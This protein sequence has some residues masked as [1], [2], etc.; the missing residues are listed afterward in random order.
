MFLRCRSGRLTRALVGAVVALL[1]G[2]AAA[3]QPTHSQTGDSQLDRLNDGYS[4]LYGDASGLANADK[5]FLVKFENDA[6]QQVVTETADY[7]GQLAD[8]LEQLGRDDPSIRLDLEPL[9][10]IE[11]ETQ[12]AATTAR[13]KSF[14]PVVGRSGADFERTLLLTLSGGLNQLRH[15]AR[16]MAEVERSDERSALLRGAENRIDTLY[17]EIEQVLEDHYFAPASSS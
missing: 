15:L 9:P 3:A 7:M 2:G 10:E 17:A 1:V 12:A 6:T 5:I 4:L 14:A 8:Q 16:V 13:I 11:R